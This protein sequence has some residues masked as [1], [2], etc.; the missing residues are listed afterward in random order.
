VVSTVSFGIYV[1]TNGRDERLKSSFP[2]LPHPQA[3]YRMQLKPQTLLRICFCL[4]ISRKTLET[5]D[6]K[7]LLQFNQKAHLSGQYSITAHPGGTCPLR[8]GCLAEHDCFSGK[9]L[10]SEKR[11]V[12]RPMTLIQT[13]SLVMVLKLPCRLPAATGSRGERILG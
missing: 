3:V 5:A 6:Q 13:L 11:T 4:W 7:G 1:Q 10:I 12:D 2:V 8:L 9:E